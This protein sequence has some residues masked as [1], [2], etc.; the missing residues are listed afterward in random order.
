MS[1]SSREA[2][3]PTMEESD[4]VMAIPA[5]L[6]HRHAEGDQGGAPV[7]QRRRTQKAQ[8]AAL[9]AKITELRA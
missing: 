5:P 3:A 4:A 1:Q 6:M 2:K 9:E 7:A 8:L